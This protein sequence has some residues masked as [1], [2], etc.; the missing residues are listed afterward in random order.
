MT[1]NNELLQPFASVYERYR[2]GKNL[3]YIVIATFAPIINY[4]SSCLYHL[5]K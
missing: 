1:Q 5:V 3:I 2:L 4:K